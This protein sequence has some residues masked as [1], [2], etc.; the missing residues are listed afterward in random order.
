V[1]TGTTKIQQCFWQGGT[2][3][4]VTDE[5]RIELTSSEGIKALKSNTW[6]EG[7]SQLFESD[8][9]RRMALIQERISSLRD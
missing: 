6:N 5:G 9:P 1:H 8:D 4:I 2:L 3:V 7:A